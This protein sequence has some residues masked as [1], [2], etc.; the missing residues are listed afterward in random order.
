MLNLRIVKYV[1]QQAIMTASES[2]SESESEKTITG[3]KQFA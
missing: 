3:L 1:L 2:E